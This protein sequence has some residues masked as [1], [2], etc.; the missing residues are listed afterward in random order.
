MASEQTENGVQELNWNV[1]VLDASKDGEVVK[2]TLQTKTEDDPKDKGVVVLR[3]YDDFEWLY[4]CLITQNKVDAVVVPPLPQ[5][6]VV[7]ANASEAK[8]KKQLGKDAKN[9]VADEF[10]K[11]CRSLEKFLQLILVHPAFKKDGILEKFLIEQEAP[12]RTKVKKGLFGSLGKTVDEMRFQGYKDRD[13]DFQKHRDFVD[14]ELAAIKEANMNF[15]KMSNTQLRVALSLGE[16]SSA[17]STASAINEDSTN[18]LK[19]AFNVFSSA[20]TTE[21]DSY[22]VMSKN[23]D[24][25]LGFTLDL[26]SRYMESAKEMLFRRTCK[27][28]EFE[29]AVKALEKA[30]PQKKEQCET[31]KNEAETAYNEITEL[32]AI[33]MKRFNRQRVLALQSSLTNFAESRIKN[34]RDT[35]AILAKLLNDVKKLGDS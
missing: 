11:E 30:K 8:S 22:D 19:P 21:K 17:L 4:H 6:P 1:K 26:Y 9:M 34:G 7:T 18:R 28:V 13:E 2:F 5:R 35:Y 33:E 20:V 12:A 23:D 25:T 27:L 32:A 31:A 10:T 14:K 3:D 24:N 16:L 29:N 15:A